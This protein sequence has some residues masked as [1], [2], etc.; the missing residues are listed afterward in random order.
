MK[1]L[2]PKRKRI[3]YRYYVIPENEK[4]LALL[5]DDWRKEYGEGLTRLHFHNFFEVGSCHVG[6]GNVLQD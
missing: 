3:E 2:T 5:G 1:R 6:K 4:V